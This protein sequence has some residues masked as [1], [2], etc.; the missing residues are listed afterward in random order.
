MLTRGG[1]QILFYELFCEWIENGGVAVEAS[2][3]AP[4]LRK[5]VWNDDSYSLP[6]MNVNPREWIK[7]S[8]YRGV[9]S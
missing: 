4:R 7:V 1:L 8:I 2:H 5:N 9:N 3:H 6:S